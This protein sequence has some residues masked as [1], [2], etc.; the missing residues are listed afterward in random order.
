VTK[1]RIFIGPA[2]RGQVS[3]SIPKTRDSSFAHAMRRLL[4]R[5]RQPARGDPAGIGIGVAPSGLCDPLPDLVRLFQPEILGDLYVLYHQDLREQRAGLRVRRLHPRRP[6]ER[7]G[8]RRGPPGPRVH[9]AAGVGPLAP[10]DEW[11]V[12]GATGG[13]TILHIF[14]SAQDAV[15]PRRLG[16]VHGPRPVCARPPSACGGRVG[17]GGATIRGSKTALP[18][19]I[20]PR[21]M[22]QA[23][24]STPRSGH[25]DRPHPGPPPLAA[26]VGEGVSRPACAQVSSASRRID[27]GVPRCSALR[28]PGLAL[29]PTAMTC[30]QRHRAGDKLLVGLA[31]GRDAV[32]PNQLC[33][34]PVAGTL[35]LSYLKR[36]LGVRQIEPL[37][38]PS[39]IPERRLF[40]LKWSSK[41]RRATNILRDRCSGIDEVSAW[42]RPPRGSDMTVGTTSA[43]RPGIT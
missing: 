3:T 34:D 13:R 33:L 31:K 37:H 23:P 1:A 20:Q 2:Q 8:S 22:S 27:P 24:P 5:L 14:S 35:H 6:G 17:V 11:R 30:P 10:L 32:E 42:R 25:G 21:R 16:K 41:P 38:T 43:S 26:L 39:A 12:A 9:R 15:L 40:R 19:R 29:L 18:G 28:R 4:T 36:G 7:R